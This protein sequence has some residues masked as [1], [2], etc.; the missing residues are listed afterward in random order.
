MSH[1]SYIK[2]YMMQTSCT[3]H[4]TISERH[5]T[6]NSSI[7]N[8]K[9]NFQHQWKRSKETCIYLCMILFFWNKMWTLIMIKEIHIIH[10]MAC[11]NVNILKHYLSIYMLQN[12]WTCAKCNVQI[13][14]NFRSKPY[15]A[16]IAFISFFG[17]IL[18]SSEIYL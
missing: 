10:F 11:M 12:M 17:M 14:P 16:P 3:L 4:C 9:W 8:L 6:L 2:I 18:M 15:T 5:T 13:L 1:A 7:G